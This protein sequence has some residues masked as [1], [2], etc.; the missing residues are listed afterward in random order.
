MPM[1]RLS[2]EEAA[3]LVDYF[4]ALAGRTD[5]AAYDPL[6]EPFGKT[7]VY[8]QPKT[9]A[10]AFGC[11]SCHLPR[12]TPGTDP[13]MG[14][15]APPFTLAGPRLRRDW[16]VALLENPET[17]IQGTKMTSFWPS[18]AKP[19]LAQGNTR[20]ITYPEFRFHLGEDAT[21]DAIAK[22]QMEMLARYLLYHY[23][24]AAPP[25]STPPA[26]PTPGD[27]R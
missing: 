9:I 16:V 4:V 20:S 10:F 6:D 22:V 19:R 12:G 11:V 7:A 1:F 5:R 8:A 2:D 14:G 18:R 24:A 13:S 26:P 17:Q 25:A 15:S 27:G 23:E 3:A 21:P